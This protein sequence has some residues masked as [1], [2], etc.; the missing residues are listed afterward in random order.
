MVKEG[1]LKSDSRR[2]IWEITEDGRK[3]LTYGLLKVPTEIMKL[4][5]IE[6]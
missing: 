2:G 6:D 5:K 3:A 4:Y 1:L